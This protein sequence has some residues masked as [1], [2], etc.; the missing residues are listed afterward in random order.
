MSVWSF[1]TTIITL[2]SVLRSGAES[3]CIF[4]GWCNSYSYLFSMSRDGFL[5]S[6]LVIQNISRR[7]LKVMMYG[8]LVL[9]LC[10]CCITHDQ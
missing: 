5:K 7:Y 2:M 1:L 8:L 4:C 6:P 3:V 10:Y 9:I